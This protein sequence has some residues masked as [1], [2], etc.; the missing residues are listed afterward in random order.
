MLSAAQADFVDW[1]TT[2]PITHLRASEALKPFDAQMTSFMAARNIPGGA[3][4]VS[5]NGKLV[6]AAGYGYADV[7]AQETVSPTS[8]FRIAS[9]SK[10]ITG[11][12]IMRL[13]ELYPDRVSLGTP[14]FSLVQIQ[15]D[16]AGDPRLSQVT[17]GQLL[18]H[19]GGWDRGRS[20]DP[21]GRPRQISEALG[22]PSPPGPRDIIRYML[23]QPLEFA[24]G[25]EHAY[26]N[27]GYCVL[28]RIIEDVSGRPY[29]QF[30]KDEVL[31]P[32]S[33]T[34]MRIGRSLRENL[35]PGEVCYYDPRNGRSVWPA[36]GA[37]EG[38]L[39]YEALAIEPMD[40]HGGW[41]ASAV[42]LVKFACAF[43]GA[44]HC[45][46]LTPESVA[47]MFARPEGPAG[48]EADGAP[49][50][51]YYAGGWSVRP[52]GDGRANHWH[53]GGLP[54]T[55]T[56]LVRRSDGLNWAVLF[57]Q[58]LDDSGLEYGDIDPALHRAANAVNDWPDWDL[59]EAT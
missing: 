22:I 55:S 49:Q 56:L 48:Y 1:R 29:E 21:M 51:A 23:G 28:G 19:T 36:S 25:A 26:S 10:P 31:G 32:L 8:L 54:G 50:A 7:E 42:D 24:P 13:M 30:V 43:D 27:F 59:W 12:A 16:A 9:L 35:A 44:E 52:T 2:I 14:A 3:L 57:N 47:V 41:I 5:R 33:I 20:F 38:S 58:G 11:V 53:A 39:A 34:T 45:P 17:V 40:S 15:A 37:E 46:I 18:Y 6:L 4:A